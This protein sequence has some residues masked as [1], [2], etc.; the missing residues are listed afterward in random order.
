MRTA[1]E[2]DGGD[3]RGALVDEHGDEEQMQ[4]RRGYGVVQRGA[5][6]CDG[7]ANGVYA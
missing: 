7:F 6:S 3:P 1:G 5:W 4:E 2:A